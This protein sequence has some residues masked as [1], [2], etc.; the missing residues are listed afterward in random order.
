MAD[1]R[2]DEL[3]ELMR[4]RIAARLEK[5]SLTVI[6]AATSHNLPRDTIRNI[7]RENGSL[8][9]IDTTV[10][11]AD[12]LQTTV[13]YLTGETP[14][15]ERDYSDE[16]TMAAAR[17]AMETARPIPIIARAGW[18]LREPIR[19][20]NDP[21]DLLFLGVPGFED[22]P[23]YAV[24]VADDHA[25]LLYEQGRIV[26]W[27]TREYAG[28][29]DGDNVIVI[30]KTP[31]DTEPK[32]HFAVTIRQVQMGRLPKR[33]VR[34]R[35]LSHPYFGGQLVS[36][37]LEKDQYPNYVDPPAGTAPPHFIQV[38]GVVVADVN[39][40]LRSVGSAHYPK[41]DGDL[42]K[43]DWDEWAAKR[44]PNADEEDLAA[45]DAFVKG[46]GGNDTT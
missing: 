27:T 5:L 20:N 11:I 7:F 44:G 3:K 31:E 36:L 19:H 16:D 46:D 4:Q 43:A 22:A 30:D 1:D 18:G 13:A 40:E 37:G 24:E 2:D 25:A 41:I 21:I 15:P 45:Y 14:Y 8:P 42:M 34:E 26:V 17:A 12:A 29:R 23:L 39:F 35:N 6:T 10:K 28:L 32:D 9:R 33:R 38:I